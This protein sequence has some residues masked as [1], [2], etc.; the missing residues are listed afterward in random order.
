MALTFGDQTTHP[1]LETMIA[2]QVMTQ[3]KTE[4]EEDED[5][6]TLGMSEVAAT[7]QLTTLLSDDDGGRR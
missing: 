3:K 2:E 7:L 5:I 1:R 6:L 4:T